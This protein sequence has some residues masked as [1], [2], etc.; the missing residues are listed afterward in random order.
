MFDLRPLPRVWS[1]AQRLEQGTHNPLVPGSNPGGPSLRFGADKA[2]LPCR[3]NVKA[4]GVFLFSRAP[5]TTAWQAS[6]IHF[7]FSIP[8]YRL[9]RGGATTRSH[10]GRGDNLFRAD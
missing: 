3:N 9:E 7:R 10:S 6:P 8:D 5:K 2:K 4:A 1:I